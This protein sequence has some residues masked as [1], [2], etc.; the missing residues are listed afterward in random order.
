MGYR[1]GTV[2]GGS[3]WPTLRPAVREAYGRPPD[4]AP[5]V[6]ATVLC[7]SPRRTLTADGTATLLHP[8][9]HSRL[10]PM[11]QLGDPAGARDLLPAGGQ[12]PL[13]RD[14]RGRAG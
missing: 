1:V 5:L 8:A 10:H 14:D 2:G 7:P 12:R 11:D 13:R 9:R 3:L 6:Q 4:R